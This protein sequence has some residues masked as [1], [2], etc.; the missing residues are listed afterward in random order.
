MA[1]FGRGK[2][3]LLVGT[4]P[5]KFHRRP[6]LRWV[7]LGAV[8]ALLVALIGL[9]IRNELA[10]SKT[11]IAQ[12]EMERVETAARY[13]RVD[14]GRCPR[15]VAELSH[16]PAGRLPYIATTG[17]DPWGRRYYLKCPGRWDEDDV[18]VATPGPD[19]EWSGGDDMSTD[20]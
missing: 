14:F 12:L 2:K 3:E 4:H 11:R 8:F 18:D 7:K 15:D 6:W 17:N 16:P 9:A 1:V 13:F 19:G 5:G 20:L 10:H